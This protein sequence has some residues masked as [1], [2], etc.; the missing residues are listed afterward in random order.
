M[1]DDG[2]T[3]ETKQIVDN[4]IDDLEIQYFYIENT[5][6]PAAPRNVGLEMRMVNM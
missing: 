5:G 3:D 1:C 2:S 6:S 4:F